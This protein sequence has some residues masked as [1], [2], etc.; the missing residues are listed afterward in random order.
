MDKCCRHTRHR[1]N[2]YQAVVVRAAESVVEAAEMVVAAVVRAQAAAALAGSFAASVRMILGTIVGGVPCLRHNCR[3]I[4]PNQSRSNL[5]LYKLDRPHSEQAVMAAVAMQRAA[6]VVSLDQSPQS[7]RAGPVRSLVL[8]RRG[9]AV[10]RA[11]PFR[12]LVRTNTRSLIQRHPTRSCASPRDRPSEPSAT[13][14]SG[15]SA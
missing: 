14:W 10:D 15:H 4:P 9:T 13:T 7:L 1:R 2:K 12:C 3:C 5:R 11:S 8:Y 6:V